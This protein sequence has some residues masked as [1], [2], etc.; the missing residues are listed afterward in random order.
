MT[1]LVEGSLR[2]S[3]DVK[4]LESV[5]ISGNVLIQNLALGKTHSL[6]AESCD[7]LF[8]D[9]GSLADAASVEIDLL[10]ALNI[11]G[12]AMDLESVMAIVV[13]NT[14]AVAEDAAS[15]LVGGAASNAWSAFFADPTDKLKLPP[16]TGII[17][18]CPQGL[19][20]DGTHKILKLA[21][22]GTGVAACTYQVVVIGK[23][24]T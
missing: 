23:Q 9:D 11:K 18:P 15:L 3:V 22:D 4:F 12:D 21:H 10:T 20:V 13:V 17:L 7:E 14:T 24:A 6:V 5:G 1:R 8:H 16:N 19:D 2:I